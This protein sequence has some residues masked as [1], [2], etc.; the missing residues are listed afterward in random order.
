MRQDAVRY[1]STCPAVYP[2]A[3][4]CVSLLKNATK[5][6]IDTANV[7]CKELK[8]KRSHMIELNNNQN[9]DKNKDDN[10][11]QAEMTPIQ[12]VDVPV[13]IWRRIYRFFSSVRLAMT[14]LIAIL[15]CCFIGVT[16]FRGE[17]A[18]TVIF[19]TLWFNWLLILLVVNVACCFFPRMWGRRLTLVSLGMILFH[20]SFVFMLSGI[21]YNSLFYFRG[22]IRLT[23]GETLASGELQSYDSTDRGRL[24]KLSRLKGETKLIKMHTGFK[25]DGVD[26][27][28]A[29]EISV[30]EGGLNK[31]EIIYITKHLEYKGFRYFNDREGYSILAIL[32][33]KQGRELYGAHIPLQSRKQKDESYLYTTGTKDGPGSF[34]FPPDPMKPLFGLQVVYLPSKLKD[35]SGAAMFKIWPLPKVAKQEPEVSTDR[36]QGQQTDMPNPHDD[37]QQAEM[38]NAHSDGKQP[39]AVMAGKLLAEGKGLIGEKIRVGDYYLEAR[40]IRYWVGMRVVYEPGQPIILAS[41]W[42]GLAGI[43]IAFIGRMRKKN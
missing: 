15:A 4:A 3:F 41:M 27:R 20:L 40:E 12:N 18:W 9:A 17:R 1:F 16:I 29:Y 5:K 43:I 33:D 24:F 26:K 39:G 30:G 22:N 37:M 42:A 14:L 7:Q 32:Y 25:V 28:A 38:S 19:S 10:N 6:G 13:T 21:I 23:E 31:Q 35:R 34:S 8:I 11:G 36:G 2:D